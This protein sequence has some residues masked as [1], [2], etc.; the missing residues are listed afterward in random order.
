MTNRNIML[1]P[2]LSLGAKPKTTPTLDP[3]SMLVMNVWFIDHLSG[4]CQNSQQPMKHH[5]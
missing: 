5:A 1:P 3:P 2:A 4:K